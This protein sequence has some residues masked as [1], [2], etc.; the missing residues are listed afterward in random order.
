MTSFITSFLRLAERLVE[1]CNR[2]KMR[3]TDLILKN[4]L[5]RPMRSTLT[6][7]ALATAIASVVALLGI[8]RGFT[9]SF[10]DIYAAHSIDIV[11]SRQGSADRL[12]SSID[13]Q[14]VAKIEALQ[15]V[16]RAAAV[17]L[18]TLSFEDEGIYGVPT[19]GIA[20][21]SWLLDDY[22]FEVSKDSGNVVSSED[23]RKRFIR[24]LRKN[25]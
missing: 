8:T 22:E 14:Y 23:V 11:V 10:A 16:E 5:R 9:R 13:E 6:L 17:L 7:V 2:G 1:D 3:F 25:L 24:L 21:G 15:T 12:S 20:D 4:L 18:E 19:M